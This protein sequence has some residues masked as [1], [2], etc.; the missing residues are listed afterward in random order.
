MKL[1]LHEIGVM[2]KKIY[3]LYKNSPKRL[4]E[5]REIGSIFEKTGQKPSKSIGT[6]WIA[7][8]VRAMEII[9]ANYDSFGAHIECLSQ[10][11]SQ[12]L[13]QAEIEGLAKKWLQGKYSMN[14][15][16]FFDSLTPIKVLSL[17]TKQEVHDPVNNIKRI[18][19]FSWTMTKLKILIPNSLD[20]SSK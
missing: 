19:E 15:A 4:R 12:A 1:F 6:R 10:T 18:N 20:E 14:F 13:K 3:Y 16:M 9:L 11:D 5:L 2:L 7:H 8:K 17:T